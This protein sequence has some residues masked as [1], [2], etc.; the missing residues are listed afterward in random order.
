MI[1]RGAWS[2]ND[3]GGERVQVFTGAHPHDPTLF[4]QHK[5]LHMPNASSSFV[6]FILANYLHLAYQ[7]F[8]IKG[9]NSIFQYYVFS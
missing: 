9:R 7:N 5:L 6:L 1:S 4:H 3:I 2:T 8:N